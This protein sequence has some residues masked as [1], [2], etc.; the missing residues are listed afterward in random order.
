MTVN[1]RRSTAVVGTGLALLVAGCGSDTPAATQAAGGAPR[2]PRAMFSGANLTKLAKALGVSEAKLQAALKSA[3]PHRGQRPP[4]SGRPPQG[5]PAPG[6]R[7]PGG[8]R[9]PGDIAAALA[10]QLKLPEAK[11]RKALQQVLP[12]GGRAPAPPAASTTPS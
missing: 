9:G 1:W 7:P 5:T 12:Q 4:N 3:L 11:V 10:K 8:G 2:G 6:Q